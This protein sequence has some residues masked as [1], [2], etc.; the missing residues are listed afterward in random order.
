LRGSVLNGNQRDQWITSGW[1]STNKLAGAW[2][3][4]GNMS[5]QR[6]T[7]GGWK[8]TLSKLMAECVTEAQ[9]RKTAFLPFSLQDCRPMGV[10]GKLEQGHTD[11]LDA[12]MH[13]SDRMVR[14][15]YDR[16]RMRVAKPTR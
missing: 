8:A 7:K 1:K 12:T 3:V 15:V 10:S 13:S 5:G 6:Y 16:R 11:T 9:K 4:F 14:Q 2:Y